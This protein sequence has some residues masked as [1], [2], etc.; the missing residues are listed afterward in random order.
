M[1]SCAASV[2]FTDAHLDHQR[3]RE[4]VSISVHH[5]VLTLGVGKLFDVGQNFKVPICD[6]KRLFFFVRLKSYLPPR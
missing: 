6:L 4:L 3:I 2:P 1:K 5:T